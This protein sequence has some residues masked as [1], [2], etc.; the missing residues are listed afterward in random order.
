M[1]LAVPV[2]NKPTWASPPWATVLLIVLNVLVYFGWQV[3]EEKAV[4][5]AAGY[6]AQTTLPALEL[7]AF[8]KH[9]GQQAQHTDSKNDANVAE[10]A[11]KMLQEKNYAALYEFMWSENQFRTELLAEH[12]IKPGDEDYPQWRDARNAFASREPVAFTARWAQNYGKADMGE[13]LQRPYTL[14]TSTFLHGS[15]DHL[16]GNMVFLFLFGFA[17]ERALGGT[18]YIVLYLVSGVG[19]STVAA[20]AYAGTGSYGLGASGAIAGLMGMYAVLYGLRR[21]KF[22]YYILFYFNYARLPALVML[23][24]WMGHELLQHWLAKGNVAYMAHFGGLACGALALWLMMA[25]RPAI[26]AP[27][28]EGAQ[29]RTPAQALPGDAELQACVQRAQVHASALQFEAACKEWR[30]AAKLRPT[31]T[32]VLQAWFDIARH[33]PAGDDFHTSARMVLQIRAKND[34]TRR[35]QQRVYQTYLQQAKP[36]IRLRPQHLVQ[37]ARALIPLQALDDAERLCRLLEKTA[38]EHPALPQL[39]SQ[40][41]N[42]WAKSGQHAQ[43]LAWQPTLHRLAPQDPVTL[44]LSGLAGR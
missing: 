40:L 13:V 43:A 33:W 41:A 15:F 34:D 2:E 32:D 30:A 23:P 19:A 11:E 12:V 17:L 42:A 36:A 35:L 5:K 29:Q 39:V 6:Y 3:R 24:V 18:L 31:D 9:L 26:Q 8:V 22:F 16:L 25:L 38:P 44:W 7:P 20:L 14:L 27:A 37:V 4:E 28:P 10:V 21:I 1:F